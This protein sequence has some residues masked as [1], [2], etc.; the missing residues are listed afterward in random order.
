MAEPIRIGAERQLFLDGY[1]IESREKMARKVCPVAKHPDNPLIRPE[2]DWEPM[3]YVTY[4]SVL[5]DEEE[6]VYKAWCHGLAEPRL[7]R[8]KESPIRGAMYYFVSED[9]IHWDRPELDLVEIAGHR[10]NIVALSRHSTH[11]KAWPCCYELFGVSKDPA[12]P[13]PERR[14]KMGYLYLNRDGGPPKRDPFHL[15][16]VRGLGVAFSADGVHWTPVEGPVTSATCDGSTHWMRDPAT[17][18]YVLYGRTKHIA[19][20]VQK[21][22]GEDKFFQQHHW[23]RAVRRAESEDFV[24]WTPDEGQLILAVDT[25]DGP[26]HEIYGMSV[27]P[28]EGIY[29]GLVQMFYNYA[30]YVYLDAQLAVSRDGVRFER[31]SDR[32]PFIPVGGVGEWDR[33]NNSLANSAPLRVGDELRFYYGG[34]N[35]L[36]S[37]VHQGPDNGGGS[38]VPFTGGVGMGTVRLD[39]FAAMQATFDAGT[40]LTKPIVFEGGALHLNAAV[41]FGLL[42]VAVLGAEGEPIEGMAAR[43]EG[44]DGVD[45][46]VPLDGLD[47]LSGRPI[48]LC[49]TL[50]N[51]RLYSFRVG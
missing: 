27:F 6:G 24:H 39:R 18:R 37:G 35:Y 17:G 7:Y 33:F 21:L 8:G 46:H 16:E 22:W 34:R 9:G 45:L 13:D 31:L 50:R 3:G 15:G 44:V 28:Y 30:D 1:L 2:A 12:D 4:G 38:G 11:E 36:H 29:V 14:Y 49:F 26:G 10:T 20:E 19:P 25:L 32:S 42:D 48:R 5:Y 51:G 23:G 43:I 47:R 40:L 41:E